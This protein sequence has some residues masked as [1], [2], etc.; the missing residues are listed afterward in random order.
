MGEQSWGLILTGSSEKQTGCLL[1]FSIE[2]Q[3]GAFITDCLAL[4][5]MLAAGVAIP[6]SAWPVLSLGLC[7]LLRHQRRPEVRGKKKYRVHFK[8]WMLSA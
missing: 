2:V 6:L 8:C 4:L 3:A 1:K 7:E 5:L